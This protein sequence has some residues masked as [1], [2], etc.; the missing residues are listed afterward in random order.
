MVSPR[1]SGSLT[2]STNGVVRIR[3]VQTKVSD[4]L[5]E[6]PVQSTGFIVEWGI[7]VP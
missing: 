6:R 5:Q 7:P 2:W 4:L 1:V 3:H